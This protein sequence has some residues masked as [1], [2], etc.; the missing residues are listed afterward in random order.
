LGTGTRISKHWTEPDADPMES[1]KK[2]EIA[3][4]RAK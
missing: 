4:K 3:Y 2:M 1:E